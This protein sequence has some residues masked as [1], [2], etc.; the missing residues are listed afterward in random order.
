MLD[1][2][3]HYPVFTHGYRDAATL[4]TPI[5]K[6]GIRRIFR[7]GENRDTSRQTRSR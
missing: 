7:L 3:M 4:T 5:P 2:Q 6:R 1:A